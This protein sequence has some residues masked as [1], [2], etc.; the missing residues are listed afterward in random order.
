M[1][2]VKQE[3]AV[4]KYA[5]DVAPGEAAAT[6]RHSAAQPGTVRA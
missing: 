4:L 5:A 3:G 1:F 6:G 2:V